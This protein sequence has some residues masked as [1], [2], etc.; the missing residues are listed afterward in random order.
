[1][2]LLALALWL[3]AA[4]PAVAQTPAPV[5]P[6][7]ISTSAEGEVRLAPNKAL[8]RLNVEARASTAAEASNQIG[9]KV[10]AVREAIRA[11]GF[12][13]DS[14]R[15]TSFMVNPIYDYQRGQKPVDYQGL[16]GIELTVRSLDRVA[17]VLDTALAAGVT[18]VP[19]V[20]FDSDSVPTARASAIARAMEK[21][22]A[23]A[24]ALAR[25]AG[26][27]LGKLL[28][29]STS[30]GG[31]PMPRAQ[32]AMAAAKGGA[33]EVERDVIVQVSVQARWEFIDGR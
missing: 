24:E 33:P 28:S 13:L 25:A 3:V 2:R 19:D 1:M 21:A 22:R 11:R 8:V 15:T 23:D 9:R 14:I 20:S 16:A 32:M 6:P 29:A 5:P 31:Y 12:P 7:E 17:P 26:G 4:A 18:Q 10:R 30:G 27:R